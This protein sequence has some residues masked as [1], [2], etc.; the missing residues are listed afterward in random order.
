MARVPLRRQDDLPDDYQYL[1]GEDA[2][3][4][5]NLLCAMANNPDALQ[6]YMRY[7][8]TLWSDGGLEADDLERCILTI[9]RELEAVYEWHQHVPIA[10]ESGVSDDEILA[11]ADG[12]RDRFDERETALLRYVEAVVRDEVDDDRFAALSEWFEPTEIVGITLIATHYLAT[13]RFLSALEVPLEDSFVGW[14]L[15]GE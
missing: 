6:S 14:D 13:A 9:A 15:E 7:G 1:L 8:T 11:I 12:D 10:R 3:G 4:E 5:L 2:L